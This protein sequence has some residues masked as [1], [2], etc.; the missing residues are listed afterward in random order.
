[1]RG[2]LDLRG[3]DELIIVLRMMVRVQ[4]MPNERPF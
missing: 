4:E 3:K 1:M 2:R